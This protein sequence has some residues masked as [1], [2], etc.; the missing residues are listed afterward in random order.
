[1]RWSSV[2]LHRVTRALTSDQSNAIRLEPCTE[3]SSVT[4]TLRTDK[5]PWVIE[6]AHE[7][8]DNEC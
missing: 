4:R 3:V 7:E 8:N 2:S 5:A 6:A 1:M